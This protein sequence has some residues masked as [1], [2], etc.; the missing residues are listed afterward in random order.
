[1]LKLGFV[2]E[3]MELLIRQGSSF[4]PYIFTVQ[5]PDTTPVNLTGCTVA[6][7]LRKAPGSPTVAVLT[8]TIT[9]PTLGEFQME[10]PKATT[11]ALV[12]GPT[13]EN[14]DSIYNW[15]MVLVDS[16][17]RNTPLYYGKAKIHAKV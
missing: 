14:P 17:G 5:N 11:G 3:E 4:G 12:C 16:S 13:P 15:D 10:M 8:C 7:Q 9:A 6:A 2:G 1:M